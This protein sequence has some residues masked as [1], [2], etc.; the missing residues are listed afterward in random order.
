[1]KQNALAALA[2]LADT[3]QKKKKAVEA[4]ELAKGELEKA[5]NKAAAAR[6]T[7]RQIRELQ[8][9]IASLT[10]RLYEEQ[11]KPSPKSSLVEQLGRDRKDAE[12]LLESRLGEQRALGLPDGYADQFNDDPCLA[13]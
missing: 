11:A 2:S 6:A 12:T 10:Q 8:V 3:D 4:V 1:V 5:N 9:K 7:D 13:P